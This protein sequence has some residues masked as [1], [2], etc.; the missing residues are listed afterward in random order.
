[1]KNPNDNGV[2]EDD[3][4]DDDDITTADKDE[5]FVLQEFFTEIEQLGISS[6]STPTSTTSD[7]PARKNDHRNNNS[8]SRLGNGNDAGTGELQ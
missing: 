8:R 1:M 6:R 4:N 7:V 3:D 5:E 2:V